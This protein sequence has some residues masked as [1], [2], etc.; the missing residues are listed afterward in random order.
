MDKGY[1]HHVKLVGPSNVLDQ[2]IQLFEQDNASTG[3]VSGDASHK[4]CYFINGSGI[5]G[6]LTEPVMVDGMKIENLMD[7]MGHFPQV[8]LEFL[9][10]GRD[11]TE[12]LIMNENVINYEN[13]PLVW[14]ERVSSDSDSYVRLERCDAP[15]V[16]IDAQGRYT[17][18][19]SI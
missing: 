5:R 13:Y 1:Y 18:D 12:R 11:R 4:I 10:M 15:W 3:F 14:G 9:N 16:I 2:V 8:T 7:L 6:I 17:Y 19:W